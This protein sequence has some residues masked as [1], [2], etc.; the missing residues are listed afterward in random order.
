VFRFI[1]P[2]TKVPGSEAGSAYIT[3]QRPT[4]RDAIFQPQLIVGHIV[5]RRNKK[6]IICDETTKWESQFE[7]LELTTRELRGSRL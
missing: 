4:C 5:L 2:I 1:W 6:E 7:S 3:I